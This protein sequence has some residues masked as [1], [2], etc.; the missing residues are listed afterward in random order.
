MVDSTS[1][2]ENHSKNHSKKQHHNDNSGSGDKYQLPAAIK[3]LLDD[4][5]L[6]EEK[7]EALKSVIRISI[8]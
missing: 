7:R 5:D 1:N 4:P 3:E 6:S 8:E 2:K